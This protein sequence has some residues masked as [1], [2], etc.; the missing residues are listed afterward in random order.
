M[1]FSNN[2]T[3]KDLQ[4]TWNRFLND[5]IIIFNADLT[6]TCTENA[7][8]HSSCSWP[9]RQSGP[10]KEKERSRTIETQRRRK[11]SPHPLVQKTAINKNYF[12]LLYKTT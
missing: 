9:R 12:T 5:L 4:L 8:Y 6:T 3:E 1:N 10:I 7:G 2:F 11:V